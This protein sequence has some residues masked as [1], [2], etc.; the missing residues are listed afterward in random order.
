MTNAIPVDNQ[1]QYCYRNDMDRTLKGNPVGFIARVDKA[2]AD[3]N[4]EVYE[5]SEAIGQAGSYW[6]Q[7]KS[8][9]KVRESIPRGD[10]LKAMERVLGVSQN[11]LLGLPEEA[12]AS[13]YQVAESR[14]WFIT[15]VLTRL[16]VRLGAEKV[17]DYEFDMKASAGTGRPAPKSDRVRPRKPHYVIA[18]AGDCMVPDI[19]DGDTI[20][21]DP[22]L[23]PE[24]G[25]W[26]VATVDGEGAIVKKLVVKD[27][28]S[29]QLLPLN[30][31]PLVIDENVRILGVV[32]SYE[33]PGP[34]GRRNAG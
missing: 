29:Q 3:N 6:S 16:L 4:L 11:Y 15:E 14:P 21:F 17:R 26:V 30:G 19:Q 28:I 25:D 1:M 2:I 20:H 5:F 18:V 22:D 33:R 10:T 8:R 32:I 13:A 27:G 12:P 24:N 9:H 7:W 23:D 34:R 31:E